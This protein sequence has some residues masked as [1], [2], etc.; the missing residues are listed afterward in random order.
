MTNI[1]EI[2]NLE[3]KYDGFSLNDVSFSVKKGEI[4]GFIGENGA[5]KTTTIKALLNLLKLDKGNVKI[6]GKDIQ[7]EEK[8]I[9]EDIGIVLDG[10]FFNGELNAKEINMILKKIYSSWDE[11][12]YFGYLKKFNLP[13]NQKISSFS[14]GMAAKLKI[15]T[16]LSHKPKLLILDEPTSGLDPIVRNDI[17]DILDE[18]TSNGEN[19]VLISS[20][21]TSD[22]ETIANRIVFIKNGSI[23]LDKNIDDLKD[24]Y[25][26][27][28]CDKETF[29]K[30]NADDYVKYKHKKDIYEILIDDKKVFSK[31]YKKYVVKEA[32]LDEIM[33]LYVRGE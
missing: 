6:F 17:L 5:G 22:L 26:I 33:L 1:L 20:H 32:L 16:A 21:I 10:S 28:K 30:I 15:I 12:Q 3:K 23:I 25:G 11:N 13:E 18:F 2:K 4:V 24:N 19:S 29:E 7:K 14:T 8:N 31:K 27:F 9:K